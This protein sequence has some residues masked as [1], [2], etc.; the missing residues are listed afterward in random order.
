MWTVRRTADVIYGQ[1]AVLWRAMG[2]LNVGH[3]AICLVAVLGIA[4]IV[5][6]VVVL[7]RRR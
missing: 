6:L 2:A 1:T 3:M 5:A 4:G 7:A